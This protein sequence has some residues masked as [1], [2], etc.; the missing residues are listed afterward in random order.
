[1]INDRKQSE[2]PKS[3]TACRAELLGKDFEKPGKGSYCRAPSLGGA[4]AEPEPSA[5]P[6]AHPGA[7]CTKPALLADPAQ[8]TRAHNK[9]VVFLDPTPA[10]G[11]A[12]LKHHR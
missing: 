11:E 10:R 4:G 2:P 12:D 9:L 3:P 6:P 7:L 5:P 8:R 1:M